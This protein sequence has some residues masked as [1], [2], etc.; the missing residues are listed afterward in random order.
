MSIIPAE[1]CTVA[2]ELQAAPYL[3]SDSR[4]PAVHTSEAQKLDAALDKVAHSLDLDLL[5][6]LS[7]AGIADS[8]DED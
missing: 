4:Y 8:V 6:Q 7:M 2:A 1:A 5:V 3:D